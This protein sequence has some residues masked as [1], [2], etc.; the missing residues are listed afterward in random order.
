MKVKISKLRA[1]IRESFGEEL[2]S[3]E[4][5]DLVDV[6]MGE[7]AYEGVRV[8]ELVD[9]VHDA[10]G[11][12]SDDSDQQSDFSGPGLVGVTD[13]GEEMVFSMNQVIPSSKS[14]YFFP[15]RE[16]A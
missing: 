6:D 8:T 10:A 4:V 11:S 3:V 5:G 9:D 15:T 14:R 7:E 16:E 13:R 1:I 12:F 2:T